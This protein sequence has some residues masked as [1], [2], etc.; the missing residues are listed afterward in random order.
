VHLAADFT[1][2]ENAPI[3]M[4]HDGQ[5]VWKLSLPLPPGQ[6]AYRFLI[7]GEWSDDPMCEKKVINPFGT[8][9]AIVEVSLNREN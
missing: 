5:G 7:D 2:W 6:Y 4:A 8:N 3:G 1:N 9:N